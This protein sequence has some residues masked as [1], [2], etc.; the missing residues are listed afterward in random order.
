MNKL[1]IRIFI[2]TAALLITSFI[3]DSVH[4]S[5]VFTAFFAALIFSVFNIFIKPVL[6]ILSLPINILSLGLFTF[7]INGII[8]SM[9]AFIVPGFTVTG[10][11]GAVIGSIFVSIL[12]IIISRVLDK[13]K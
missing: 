12:N 7:I 11:F 6:I 1:W 13:N 10:F 9:V 8:F 3:L 2:Y 4:I 5:G